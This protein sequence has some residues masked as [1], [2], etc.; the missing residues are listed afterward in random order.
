MADERGYLIL[1]GLEN[2]R[3]PEHWQHWLADRLREDGALVRY[4]QLPDPDSPDREAWEEVVLSELAELGE[5]ERF[6]IC[7]S[8]SVPTWLGIGSRIRSAQRA[9][10]TLLV[11]APAPSVLEGVAP[12]FVELPPRREALRASGL[13]TLVAS[14]NDPYDPAGARAT[15]GWLE[16]PIQVIHGAGHFRPEDGYGP[17]PAALEWCRGA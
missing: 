16:V 15:H 11:A 10:R 3:P 4:P 7:H 5:R 2:R 14:D 8:L 9:S 1:H 17:W 6:V 12:G 13:T